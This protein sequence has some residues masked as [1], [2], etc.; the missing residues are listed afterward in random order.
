MSFVPA[1]ITAMEIGRHLSRERCSSCTNLLCMSFAS[2]PLRPAL[3][4]S[5]TGPRNFLRISE[6]GKLG[7]LSTA[8]LV[9]ES[10]KTRMAQS[11]VARRVL[12]GDK[13]VEQG[14]RDWPAL[15]CRRRLRSTMRAA[16]LG[17]SLPARTSGDSV[18]GQLPIP[19]AVVTPLARIRLGA[20]RLLTCPCRGITGSRSPQALR[21]VM[22]T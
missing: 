4:T 1:R 5:A 12:D 22:V 16:L 8:P 20:G 17:E 14:R 21:P 7:A 18:V 13:G 3:T 11:D 10:P 15:V 2:S 19:D 9:R 6:Y